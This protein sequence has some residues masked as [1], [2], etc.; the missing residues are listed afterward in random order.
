MGDSREMV[1]VVTERVPSLDPDLASG[2]EEL[3]SD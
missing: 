2:P 3:T 1:T